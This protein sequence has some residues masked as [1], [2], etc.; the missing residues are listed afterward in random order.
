MV[1][2]RK[3]NKEQ[4]RAVTCD[5]R[6]TL[7]IAG[8]G[9]GKTT[10]IS[11][12]AAYL[13]KKKIYLPEEILGLTF[14]DK[15]AKEMED[16]ITS[17]TN[18]DCS[19]LWIS[20]FHA[21]CDR[22][23]KESG[24]EI[25]IPIDFK[26]IEESK[27]RLLIKKNIDKFELDYYA[28][29]GNPMS[30]VDSLLSHFSELKDNNISPQEYLNFSKK[31]KGDEKKRVKEIAKAFKLYQELLLNNNY[32]DFSDLI[33]YTIE[34]FKKRPLV[35]KRY[36]D[37]FKYLLVDEFQD[38]NKSQYELMKL[39]SLPEGRVFISADSNQAIYQWRGAHSGNIYQFKKDYSKPR[40]VALIKNY[41]S[42]QN[43]LDLSN[44]F[45]SLRNPESKRLVAYKK[46][47]GR[48][49]HLHL[50][51]V[52]EERRAVV[53]KIFEISKEKNESFDNFAILARTNNDANLM[54]QS[55]KR[56]GL[57]SHFIAMRGLYQKSIIIDIISY[58]NLINNYYDDSAFYRV[59][60]FPFYKIKTSDISKIFHYSKKSLKSVY[61]IIKDVDKI[62]DVSKKTIDKVKLILSQVEKDAKSALRLEVSSLL[63]SFLNESGYLNY[64]SKEGSQDDLDYLNQF[65]DRIKS[66]EESTLNP[67]L[68]DFMEEIDLEINFGESGRLQ[69]DSYQKEESV[70]IM[71][72]HGSKGL[73]FNH[74]FII[75][76]VDRKFPAIK[77]RSSLEIPDALKR[78][79]T[80]KEACEDEERKLF[81]VAMTRAKES[82]FFTSAENYG[83]LKKRKL[84]KFLIEI[85]YNPPKE[86]DSL[87]RDFFVKKKKE[88]KKTKYSIPKEFSF[89]QLAVFEKCPFQYKLKYLV[90]IPSKEKPTSLFGRMMHDL[91]CQIAKRSI[92]GNIELK[93]SLRLYKEGWT[94]EWFNSKKE[95][96]LYYDLGKKIIKD[97]HCE[98]ENN[99]LRPLF[100]NGR[101][102]LEL[103]FRLKIKDR[104]IKGRIDR[105]DSKD[106][107][108][109]IIDYKSGKFKEKTS[110]EEKRQLL[111]YQLA[112]QEMFNLKATKLTFHYLKENKKVSF[113]AKDL[114]KDEFK[115]ELLKETERIEKSDFQATPGYHCKYCDFNNICEKN[116]D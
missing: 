113:L 30:I 37:V 66:F 61:E 108:I 95:R 43:I 109:E 6:P 50:E 63:I 74:L 56:I 83:G 69:F 103:F 23:L 31:L 80:H 97:F 100:L 11:C 35:L 57:P 68:K 39:I 8:P 91:L 1:D 111:I 49:E 47:R 45:I 64:L 115:K 12:R 84:S 36:K 32:L 2:L 38:T 3:L 14:G 51:T 9:T 7:V 92:E 18:Q 116:L 27:A 73:E 58:F 65:L 86:K 114:K 104:K 29:L 99:Q 46:G 10:V 33:N 82:L 59:L 112:T 90:K 44:K 42:F 5:D 70:K 107:E 28:P 110:K 40:E 101:P 24:L 19:N 60:S 79:F 22:V 55:C 96:G 15:A 102:A 67:K 72:V 62:S 21:F 78:D 93:E 81:Y 26:I 89:S 77:K 48:V 20:T 75:N 98:I 13:I 88:L 34:L 54:A 4:K 16:R 41:R 25:G 85:G 17:I 76:L 52:E 106:G 87:K 105:I 71:T 94:G 53:N